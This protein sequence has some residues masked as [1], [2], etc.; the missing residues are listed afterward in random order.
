[1]NKTCQNVVSSFYWLI[2]LL[3]VFVQCKDDSGDSL[4]PQVEKIPKSV[5]FIGNSYT[6]Y[7]DLEVIVARLASADVVYSLF[8][9]RTAVG[10]YKLVEH[11]L[12]PETILAIKSRKWDLIVLQEMSTLPITNLNEFSDGAKKLDQII[13]ETR[14]DFNGM[15]LYTTWGRRDVAGEASM[16]ARGITTF[17]QMQDALSSAYLQVGKERNA[18]VAPV[19]I[20]WQKV[21]SSYEGI[22]DLYNSDGTHPSFAGS[23]LTA[24][25]FFASICDRSPVGNTYKE[26]LKQD[27]AD[28]LQKKAYEAYLEYK[29]KGYLK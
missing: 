29:G 5:L 1:M 21:R 6:Y 16:T 11:A 20:A 18:E 26:T 22:I 17:N 19:G 13:K 27:V 8:T 9:E 25:V 7:N 28:I 14:P 15:L 10:S 23:Y 12:R 2:V 3:V 24:C 4:K